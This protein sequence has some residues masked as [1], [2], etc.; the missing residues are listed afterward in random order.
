MMENYNFIAENDENNIRIDLYLSNEI[1][2]ISRSRIQKLIDNQNITVNGNHINKN[3]KIK[4]GDIIDVFVPDAVELDIKPENIDLDIIYEDNSV[5]VINKKKG[6][7]VHPAPGHYSGTLV[8]ALLYHCKGNLSGINGIL[9]PGIVHRIDKDTSGILVIAKND[10]A[11]KFLASQLAQHS[12]TRIYNAIVFN[13]LKQDSGTINCP[14]GRHHI[15]RKKMSVT[16]KNSK[17]AITHYKVIER[18]GKFNLIEL[19]LETGRTHQIRV[20]MSFIGYP[21]LGDTVYGSKKQPFNLN[22]QALHAKVL[23]FIHPETKEYMEF[24]SE[25][26]EYFQN[27]INILKNNKY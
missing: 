5:I 14:I 10:M 20:H 16:N 2:N 7:V 11:H 15:E 19:K 23:G 6:M 9:R 26:P 18:F 1:E 4:T 25:L 22:G 21:L 13:N 3:Y 27:L 8:N 24:E 17:Q 12:M